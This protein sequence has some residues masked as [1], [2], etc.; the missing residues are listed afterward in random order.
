MRE[1]DEILEI[2]RRHRPREGVLATVV[3]VEGSAYRRPGARMLILP[4]GRRIGTISGGCLEGDVAR[5]AAWWT[6]AGRGVVRV[7]DTSSDDDVVWEFGLGC[8]GVIHLLLEP[9]SSPSVQQMLDFLDS[10][11][12][13]RKPAVIATL[14]RSADGGHTPGERLLFG[15]DQVFGGALAGTAWQSKAAGPLEAA[16]AGRNSRL[17]HLAGA[18]FF[19][20]W[21]GPP[22]SLV[23]FGAGHDAIP[24]AAMANTFGWRVTVADGRPAYARSSRFPG[25]CVAVLPPSGDIGT[26]DFDHESAVVMMTHNY[27]LDRILLP[28]I[29]ARKPAYV[30]LLG[31]RH[32]AERLFE[33]TGV[34][35]GP[36]LHYPAGLDIGG[37]N[38]EAIA[39]AIASEIQAVIAG[40]NGGFL[41][42]RRQPI[43]LPVEQVGTPA[44]LP[45]E[46]SVSALCE[47]HV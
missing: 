38:P 17:L 7:Y 21:V 47:V 3:H 27:P 39:L 19:I 43:H 29:A 2:W 11:Q 10:H 31:P 22:Q 42:N 9:L 46:P 18:Q 24:L 30:G 25:A 33:D 45:H 44:A 37:D 20:E 1:L 8:R 6:S 5:K 12:S 40:R 26:I 23:I 28:Q 4:D 35:P 15:S 34:T 32:R 13:R 16:F 41:K 14:I 36:E